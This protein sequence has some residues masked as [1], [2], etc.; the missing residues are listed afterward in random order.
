MRKLLLTSVAGL[1]L[2]GCTLLQP[3]LPV[4]VTDYEPNIFARVP[5]YRARAELASNSGQGEQLNT[6]ALAAVPNIGCSGASTRTARPVNEFNPAYVSCNFQLARSYVADRLKSA[7]MRRDELTMLELSGKTLVFV[8][9]AGTAGNALFH[10]AHAANLSW[11]FSAAVGYGLSNSFFPAQLRSAYVAGT[12]ALACV[13]TR[14]DIAWA[15]Y[16]GLASATARLEVTV[17]DAAAKADAAART[18]GTP[19]AAVAGPPSGNSAQTRLLQLSNQ[20]QARAQTQRATTSSATR[21]ATTGATSLQAAT[22]AGN[23]SDRG[24]TTGSNAGKTD[25]SATRFEISLASAIVSFTNLISRATNDRIDDATPTLEQVRLNA[26]QIGAATNGQSGAGAPIQVSTSTDNSTKFV[27]S[28]DWLVE[29]KRLTLEAQQ[30]ALVLDGQSA[31]TAAAAMGE[32]AAALEEVKAAFGATRPDFKPC[33][34]IVLAVPGVVMPQA[35][36]VD[37]ATQ[38]VAK[39]DKD[40]D[41]VVQVT[42]GSGTFEVTQDGA[43]SADAKVQAGTPVSSGFSSVVRGPI[44]VRIPKNTP[45]G[46]YGFKVRDV[47]SN[48]TSATFSIV[49]K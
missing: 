7:T 11:A 22:P 8:G 2:G 23:A 16:T 3:S 1:G 9:L 41:V 17:T 45:A 36:T 29:M 20:I 42:G 35:V 14:A 32:L 18:A 24:N 44:T 31:R 37:T 49:V 33:V 26:A 4:D 38:D 34:D 47:V 21:G 6:L 43:A 12:N 15:G 13:A 5:A 27:V 19:A 48:G 28:Q 30:A 10:G 25:D 40:Q 39:S 46:T